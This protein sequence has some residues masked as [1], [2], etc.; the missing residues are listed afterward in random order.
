MSVKVIMKQHLGMQLVYELTVQSEI[1]GY[2]NH[3]LNVVNLLMNN[4][5]VVGE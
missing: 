2:G 1:A 3:E 4:R 5:E